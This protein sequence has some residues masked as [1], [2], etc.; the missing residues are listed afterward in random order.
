MTYQLH[1]IPKKKGYRTIYAPDAEL[2]AYQRNLIK[3]YENYYQSQVAHTRIAYTMHGF[4]TGRN[5]VTAAKQHAP[6]QY[7]TMMDIKNFFDTVHKSML[8]DF[9]SKDKHLFTKTGYCAQGFPTSPI[10]AN[11]ALIPVTQTMLTN[12]DIITNDYCL[13]IY[14]D[15]ITISYNNID[16]K[17]QIIS[18]VKSTL[19]QYGFTIS[20]KKTRTRKAHNGFRRILG[21][22]VS[23]TGVRATRVTIRKLR[24][25]TH[26]NNQSSITGLQEWMKTKQPTKLQ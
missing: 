22:N 13:T 20:D 18:A 4:L 3:P 24:A 15:D 12:L 1:K 8:P 19:T 14:A 7:T 9:I 21:I 10:L 23:E 2:K 5:C 17:H 11:I 26:Q 16:Y 25:A 6:Y